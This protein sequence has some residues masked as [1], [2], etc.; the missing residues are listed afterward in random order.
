ML[1]GRLHYERFSTCVSAPTSS[2]AHAAARVQSEPCAEFIVGAYS[3]CDKRSGA[4]LLRSRAFAL[5]DLHDR[6]LAEPDIAA[7]QAVTW[8]SLTMPLYENLGST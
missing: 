1:L 8:A 6:I 3:G 5:D 2:S 7:D 4:P